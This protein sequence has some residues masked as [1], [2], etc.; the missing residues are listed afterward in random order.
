[1]YMD[2]TDVSTTPYWI[3][4]PGHGWLAVPLDTYPD[5][6]DHGTG[7]GYASPKWAY[8]EED[9]EA[10]SFLRA[11]P[12]IDSRSIPVDILPGE[13]AGRQMGRIPDARKAGV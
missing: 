1:M 2:T 4:D 9:C 6:L 5:A 11:H 10:G 8:L 12:E 3:I 7:Y 13:W